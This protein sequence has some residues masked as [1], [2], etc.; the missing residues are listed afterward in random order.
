[1]PTAHTL[2]A[3]AVAC[4]VLSTLPG[5]T[6]VYL[7]TRTLSQGT[8]AGI[9]SEVGVVAGSALQV[10]ATAAG[11]SALLASSA[12][13]FAIVKYFGAAY[14]I[15]LGI[16][17]FLTSREAKDE[18]PT[19][20]QSLLG[21]CRQGFVITVLNPKL[22]VFLLAFLPQF[23]EPAAGPVWLQI[24]LLGTVLIIVGATTDIG[25]VLLTGLLGARLPRGSSQIMRGSR[26]V[27]GFVYLALG[28]FTAITGQRP[29]PA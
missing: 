22:T 20:P 19:R 26:L 18:Q 16:R 5:P 17:S 15:A 24:I 10:G 11:L 2:V 6:V 29:Q 21:I 4:A 1:M 14:L 27:S 12:T 28:L 13:W 23:V 9:V 7:V 8:R 3:F 25:Y